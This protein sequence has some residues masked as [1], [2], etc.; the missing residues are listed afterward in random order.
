[1]RR[2][3]PL[4]PF[5]DDETPMSWAARQAAF[6]TGGRVNNFLNDLGVPIMDLAR[7]NESATS[8]LCEIAGQD[9]APVLW[10][11]ISSVGK[12]LQK[13]RGEEFATEFTTG[14]VTRVCPSCLAEDMAEHSYPNEA[15]RHRLIWRLAP[16]RTCGTHGVALRDLRKGTWDDGAHELQSMRGAIEDEMKRHM[17]PRPRAVSPLQDYVIKR[18]EGHDGPAWLDGQRIDQAVRA[19]EMLGALMAFGAEQTASSM[20]ETMWDD[21][22]RAGWPLVVKG[23]EAVRDHLVIRIEEQGKGKGGASP[24]KAYGMLYSWLSASRLSKDPGPIRSV[25]RGVILDNTPMVLGHML[26]GEPVARPKLTRVSSIAAAEGMHSSTAVNVLRAAGLIASEGAGRDELVVDYLSAKQLI[27]RVKHAVPVIQVPDMMNTSRPIVAALIE[28]KLL[29]RV[30]EQPH[31]ESKI[32]KAVDGRDIRNLLRWL[33][34]QFE[35]VEVVPEEYVSI[36]KTA[37]RCRAK[38]GAILELLFGGYLK[39]VL[40][41]SSEIGLNAVRIDP[42]ELDSL[43]ASPPESVSEAVRFLM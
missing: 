8:R 33:E 21:A 1:M 14:A 3:S 28:L 32:G 18:L 22:G 15:L 7:G 6:H 43:L 16:V 40:R 20:S 13:L 38:A 41:D 31:L 10:N 42:Q 9:P 4:L 27:D 35:A 23:E 39:N 37:E 24:R 12:R 36:A 5:N 25:L 34:E 26:L 11:T 19:T 29:K 30:Q 2:L 17:D